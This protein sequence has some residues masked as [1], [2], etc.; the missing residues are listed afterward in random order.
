MIDYSYLKKKQLSLLSHLDMAGEKHYKIKI[1]DNLSPI[2][3]HI[4]HCLYV[5][6]LWIR[7]Y[8]LQDNELA[9]KLKGVA[10]SININPKGRGLNLPNYQYLYELTKNEFKKNLFFTNKI[11]NKAKVNYF[12]Q[13]LINHHSQHLESIK[14][15]LNLINLKNYKAKEQCFTIIEEKK[16]TFEPINIKKGIFQVG[17]NNNKQ[18]SYDNEKPLNHIK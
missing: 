15:I 4:I 5:E 3:W 14:I 8:F 18:F 1:D 7:S 2:G 11:K 6:C 17:S 16:F 10:D 12:L 13:F 9:N